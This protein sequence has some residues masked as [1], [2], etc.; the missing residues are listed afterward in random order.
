MSAARP[1]SAPQ[2]CPDRPRN[3]DVHPSCAPGRAVT[4]HVYCSCSGPCRRL[5]AFVGGTEEKVTTAV[6]KLPSLLGSSGKIPPSWCALSSLCAMRVC[7]V[8]CLFLLNLKQRAFL[9][10]FLHFL[11]HRATRCPPSGSSL[12]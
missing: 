7:S 5:L 10:P 2:I 9:L 6:A 8:V 4:L 1:A 12:N 3:F 11:T